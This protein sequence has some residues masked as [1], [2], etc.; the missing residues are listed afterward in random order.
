VNT[1][2]HSQHTSA[3]VPHVLFFN[4]RQ[5]PKNLFENHSL[6]FVPNFLERVHILFR[7]LL[8][9]ILCKS[10]VSLFIWYPNAPSYL[11]S[12]SDKSLSKLDDEEFFC[13]LKKCESAPDMLHA[14][15]YNFTVICSSHI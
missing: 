2:T 9:A 7:V 13:F 1:V 3:V 5:R 6:C 10:I 4:G 11:I 12:I 14:A 8:R 15:L